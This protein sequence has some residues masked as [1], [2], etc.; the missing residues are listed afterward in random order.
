M[1]T[2]MG[3]FVLLSAALHLGV[4]AA[5]SNGMVRPPLFPATL[6]VTLGEVP[7]V[8]PS[9]PLRDGESGSVHTA[10][11]QPPRNSPRQIPQSASPSQTAQESP[12]IAEHPH[13]P[14]DC[15]LRRGGPG[16]R[17]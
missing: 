12:E 2:G 15:L 3:R 17:R 1:D 7:D 13:P 11:P 14:L 4:L 9:S 16:G 6:A 5:L 10:R 8:A